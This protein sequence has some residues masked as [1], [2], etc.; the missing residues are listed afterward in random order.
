LVCCR[1]SPRIGW[2]T[3]RDNQSMDYSF[4]AKQPFSATC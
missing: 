1:S 3:G 2:L 4:R